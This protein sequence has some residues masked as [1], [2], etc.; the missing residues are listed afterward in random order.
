MAKSKSK[1]TAAER[2][3]LREALK[4]VRL[5]ND[6]DAQFADKAAALA[7]GELISGKPSAERL[8]NHFRDFH[9]ASISWVVGEN[10]TRR[11]LEQELKK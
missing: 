4:R 11:G 5:A 7:F 3:T 8:F 1:Y 2:R 10:I 6:A 9:N